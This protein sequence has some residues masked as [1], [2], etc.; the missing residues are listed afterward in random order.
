MAYAANSNNIEKHLKEPQTSLDRYRKE[1]HL[2]LS[3][4]IRGTKKVYFDTNFWIYLREAHLGKT[5]NQAKLRLLNLVLDLANAGRAIFPISETGFIEIFKQTDP[6]SLEATVKLVDNLSSGVSLIHIEERI[7]LEMLRFFYE[8]LGK[9]THEPNALVWTKLAYVMGFQSPEFDGKNQNL[10]EAIGKAFLDEMWE[11]QLSDMLE[12]IGHSAARSLPQMPDISERLNLGKSESVGD[13]HSFAKMLRIELSG[14]I[15]AYED[16]F[17]E[18]SS[19]LDS[20]DPNILAGFL[21]NHLTTLPNSLH[22][23][24]LVVQSGLHA[25]V[26]W[27]KAH[28]FK[29]TDMND[30]RHAAGALPYCDYFVTENPLRHLVCQA[31]LSYHDRYSWIVLSDVEQAVGELSELQG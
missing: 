16:V 13:A 31:S 9:E 14:S 7:R 6:V 27:N 10:F 26:R 5:S 19:R 29:P 30:F 15:Q 18:L 17:H 28:K 21:F 8:L 11:L 25:A 22:L 23:P 2:A 20:T 3:A 24:S 1:K 4:S 12:V